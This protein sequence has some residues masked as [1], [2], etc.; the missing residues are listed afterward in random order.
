MSDQIRNNMVLTL[1]D[2]HSKYYRNPIQVYT[3]NIDDIIEVAKFYFAP[4]DMSHLNKV[5]K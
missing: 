3:A 5:L 4:S 1:Q 2:Y